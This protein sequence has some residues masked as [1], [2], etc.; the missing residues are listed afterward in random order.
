[1]KADV[2]ALWQKGRRPK[3]K[4]AKAIETV[5]A[6]VLLP[7]SGKTCIHVNFKGEVCGEKVDEGRPHGWLC[8]HHDMVTREREQK[9]AA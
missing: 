8:T 7:M 9:V 2:L 3:F 1:M 4:E 6:M 5:K